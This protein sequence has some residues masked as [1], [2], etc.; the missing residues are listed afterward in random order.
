MSD[1]RLTRT[2]RCAIILCGNGCTCNRLEKPVSERAALRLAGFVPFRLNRL[3]VAVSEYLAVI[4]RDRFALEI[5]EWRVIATVGAAHGR[6]AQQVAASTRMHKTRVSRALLQLRRRGLIER[7]TSRRDRRELPLRLTPAGRR[8]YARLVPLV[9]ERERTLLACLERPE[10]RALL[11][12]LARLE[13]FLGLTEADS[14][15]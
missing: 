13:E 8:L 12:A 10:Q 7:R 9:L 5:P 4:Y 2:A 3:A 15:C 1:S 14:G 6:T 11:A